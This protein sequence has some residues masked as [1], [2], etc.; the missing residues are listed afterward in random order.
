MTPDLSI[1]IVNHC[2]P[3]LT[4]QCL[5]SIIHTA[6]DMPIETLV[7]N[8]T[9][10]DAERLAGLAN[11]FRGSP[12]SSQGGFVRTWQNEQPLGFAANQNR[13]F[14]YATG[15][16]L[17]PLN[18][19]T[20]VQPGALRE[21]LAFMDV[22]PGVAIAG[23]RLVHPDGTLQPSCRNFPTPLSHFLEASGLW[24]LFR[25]S[26]VVGCVYPLCSP[27]TEVRDVDWLTGACLVVRA[28]AAKQVGYY[29]AHL[30]PFYAEDME[31]CW[32]MRRAGWR[33]MFDPHATVV[34]LE[35]RSPLARRAIRM[36]S[37]LYV[38]CA[39]HYPPGRQRAMRY[40]T[41]LALLPRWLT[42]RR[43]DQRQLYAE[44]MALRMPSVDHRMA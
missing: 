18:S 9:P 2:T 3:D 10:D 39:H 1:C 23:P 44:L 5:H 6:G 34:H 40:A 31:W 27:H 33:V 26:R 30:F 17:M 8:N 43:N 16:Y 22:H 29:A 37:G 28:V 15:R 19:D 35:S 14:E 13:L 41:I 32:R 12:L 24:K 25:S 42:A 20:V 21:L 38:F 11:R 7:V 4:E 36:Y